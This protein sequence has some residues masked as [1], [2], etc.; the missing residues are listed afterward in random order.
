M[1][2]NTTIKRPIPRSF[3]LIIWKLE[4]FNITTANSEFVRIYRCYNLNKKTYQLEKIDQNLYNNYLDLVCDYFET[5]LMNV[6]MMNYVVIIFVGINFAVFLQ[7][8]FW[9]KV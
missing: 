4:Q 8:F 5:P 9:S 7:W 3:A 6:E 2:Q 1:V